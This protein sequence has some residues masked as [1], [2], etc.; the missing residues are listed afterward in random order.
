M[1]KQGGRVEQTPELISQLA[2]GAF[3]MCHLVWCHHVKLQHPIVDDTH[4]LM[5][6][7]VIPAKKSTEHM[8]R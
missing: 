1:H 5:L 8:R 7:D 6:T 3:F 4:C 2:S